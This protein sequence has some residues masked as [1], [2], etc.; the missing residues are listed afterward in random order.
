[1]KIELQS[2]CEWLNEVCD[3][4][5]PPNITPTHPAIKKEKKCKSKIYIQK[6]KQT[7][8][9]VSSQVSIVQPSF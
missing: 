5:Y 2:V 9:H 8:F 1:M 3:S 7:L 6:E 4:A